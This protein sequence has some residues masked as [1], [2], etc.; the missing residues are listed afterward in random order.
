L[1]GP[2]Q[3]RPR[4]MREDVNMPRFLGTGKRL[5]SVARGTWSDEWIIIGPHDRSFRTLH[6]VT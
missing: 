2:G 3:V 4:A 5:S 1:A 6:S